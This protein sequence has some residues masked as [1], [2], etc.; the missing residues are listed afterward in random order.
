MIYGSPRDATYFWVQEC[1]KP[2]SEP[3]WG[4]TTVAKTSH[5]SGGSAD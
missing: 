1:I 2:N 3:T 4:K 5:I